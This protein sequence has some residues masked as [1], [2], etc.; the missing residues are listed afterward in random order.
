MIY[1]GRDTPEVQFIKKLAERKDAA[2]A[3]AKD[4]AM[5]RY[6]Q[7]YVINMY[8]PELDPTVRRRFKVSGGIVLNTLADKVLMPLMGWVRNYHGY[9][10]CDRRE[11]ACFGPKDSNAIDMMHVNFSYFY[12]MDDKRYKLGDLLTEKG[13]RLGWTYDIGDMWRH[14]LEVEDILSPEESTGACELLEGSGR[15]PPEDGHG[16]VRYNKTLQILKNKKHPEYRKKL[17][18]CG[19]ACNVTGRFD[20][21]EFNLAERQQAL[22]EALASTASTQSGSKMY[23]TQLGGFGGNLGDLLRGRVGKGQRVVENLQGFS[24]GPTLT[25]TISTRADKKDLSLCAN[26][27]KPDAQSRC[28]RCRVL[29]YC[30]KECQTLHWKEGRH[31]LACVPKG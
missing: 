12:L 11:G 15:C 13:A 30:S 29:R 9:V 18:E 14:E 2:L 23:T 1:S 5:Q 31:K 26:C 7:D 4:G 3:A 22:K 24:N 20:F 19:E 25:E 6:K 21:T 28:G 8:M 27:G 16:N 17:A 10:F